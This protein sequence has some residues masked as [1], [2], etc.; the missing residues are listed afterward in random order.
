L[1]W[2][3]GWFWWLI[4]FELLAVAALYVGM[5]ASISAARWPPLE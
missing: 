3:G 1:A 2:S 5:R 4:M